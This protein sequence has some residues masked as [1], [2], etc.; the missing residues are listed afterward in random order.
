MEEQK[1]PA[2]DFSNIRSAAPCS[3]TEEITALEAA[4]RSDPSQWYYP[5]PGF[6][7]AYCFDLDSYRYFLVRGFAVVMAAG[8]GTLGSDGVVN[9][10]SRYE[11]D[12]FCA[13]IEWLKGERNAF[14][15]RTGSVA[16]RADWADGNVAMTGKS[17][18]GTLPFALAATGIEGLKTIIPVAGIADWYTD[19]NQQGAQRYYPKE[20]L[21]SMLAYFCSSRFN[22]PA[23]TAAQRE[24]MDAFLC[25]LS[26][27]QVPTGFDYGPF[28][29][30]RSYI[31]HAEKLRCSAL[32]V[33]GLN[34]DNV[35]TKQFELMYR[36]FRNAGRDVKLLLHQGGHITPSMENHGYGIRVDGG[37]YNDILNRWI[38]RYFYG[39]DS[40]P[41]LL[42]GVLVQSNLDQ[43]RW[44]HEASWEADRNIC[45]SC[46][47]EG[48]LHPD[49]EL[50]A[51]SSGGETAFIDTDLEKAGIHAE[52]F[53]EKMSLSSSN[54]NCRYL[55]EKQRENL[56][57]KGTVRVSF[58][59]ALERGDITHQFGAVCLSDADK[60]TQ[61]LGMN[62]DRPDDLKLTLLL[63]DLAEDA[64]AHYA[65]NNTGRDIVP[66]TVEEEGGIPLGSNLP[67]INLCRFE[68]VSSNYKVISRSYMDLCNP[69]AGYE[70]ETAS[71]FI[72]PEP[73]AARDYT[74]YMNPTYYTVAAGHRLAVVIGTED[75]VNCLL[76]KEYTV[77]IRH[78]SVQIR[79]PL[80]G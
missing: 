21:L 17:Y 5:D 16:V 8:P 24:R 20:M 32:I 11:T 74:V 13:V 10:G 7:G 59:A 64:F 9:C 76:H 14:A 77:A 36:C 73:G 60:K 4:L 68:T 18:A 39:T 53:D 71:S 15:D 34:D 26:A 22:D 72:I 30:E 46:G 44:I 40:T 19:S 75:P 27:D 23:L 63:V 69:D 31:R 49:P 37:F 57:I 67:P 38:T 33:H 56:T 3:P 2:P 43:D 25:R 65:H 41:D 78:E 42:P 62:P 6:E 47:K 52:N 54:A 79:V 61:E 70:P 66:V 55:S 58:R 35:A 45:L 50:P 28:W 29:E 51:L 80:A 48:G 12:S 1:L